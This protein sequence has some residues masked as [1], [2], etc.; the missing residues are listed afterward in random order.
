VTAAAQTEGS[1]QWPHKYQFLERVRAARHERAGVL[2]D[3]LLWAVGEGPCA[4][5]RSARRAAGAKEMDM[6]A[7]RI[8]VESALRTLHSSGDLLAQ[9]VAICLFD[10]PP[11]PSDVAMNWKKFKEPA[12]ADAPAI[13]EL[14][15]ALQE[16]ESWRYVTDATNTLKH[17]EALQIVFSLGGG[18]TLV[19]FKKGKNEYPDRSLDEISAIVWTV[20]ERLWELAWALYEMLDDPA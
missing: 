13:A 1:R 16:D 15:D 4:G 2:F 3:S 5:L 17:V 10:P 14:F 7:A 18:I 20:Q 6:A 12:R 8:G 19:G 9:L 11:A